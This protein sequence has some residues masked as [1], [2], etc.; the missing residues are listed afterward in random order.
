MEVLCRGS[1]FQR[2]WGLLPDGPV[3]V[4]EEEPVCDLR[5]NKVGGETAAQAEGV[6]QL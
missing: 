3:A 5:R 1:K 6:D 4:D 2:L